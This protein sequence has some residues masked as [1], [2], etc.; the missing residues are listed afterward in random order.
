MTQEI[1]AH[2]LA[3]SAMGKEPITVLERHDPQNSWRSA[4]GKFLAFT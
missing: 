4:L 2:R 1:V 3:K